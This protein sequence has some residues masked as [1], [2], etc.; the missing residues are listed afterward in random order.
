MDS[1]DIKQIVIG[2]H[3]IES[4]IDAI[5]KPIEIEL[6]DGETVATMPKALYDTLKSITF[7][8]KG[9]QII[10]DRMDIDDLEEDI[11]A[12]EELTK[13]GDEIADKLFPTPQK[14]NKA[15][16]NTNLVEGATMEKY[17]KAAGLVDHN[18]SRYDTRKYPGL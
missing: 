5:L 6:G 15:R 4:A 11:D 16:E 12:D 17:S 3:T 18:I 7:D 2:Y 1:S 9:I 10:L 8:C 13:A 14:R